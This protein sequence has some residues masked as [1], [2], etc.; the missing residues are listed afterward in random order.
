MHQMYS[1]KHGQETNELTS[2]GLIGHVRHPL[3]LLSLLRLLLNSFLNTEETRLTGVFFYDGVTIGEIVE[4]S[5]TAV[6]RRWQMIRS[7]DAF[8]HLQILGCKPI[9]TRIYPSWCMHAKD[10]DLVR[11]YYPELSKIIGEFN[12]KKSVFETIFFA[13]ETN[14]SMR[15]HVP[16]AGTLLTPYH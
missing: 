11:L 3:E 5:A 7:N 15:I 9:A 8:K 12:L 2:L 1:E 10:G 6:E 14:P 16:Q 13:C 4:G